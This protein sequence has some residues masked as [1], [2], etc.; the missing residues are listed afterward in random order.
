MSNPRWQSYDVTQALVR[1]RTVRIEAEGRDD[2]CRRVRE[3]EGLEISYP[4]TPQLLSDRAA[5]T[6]GEAKP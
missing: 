6:V 5:V 3:G 2:A 4:E 1:Y